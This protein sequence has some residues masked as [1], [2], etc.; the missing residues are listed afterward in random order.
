MLN[1]KIV[2]ILVLQEFEKD[3]EREMTFSM[4]GKNRVF[5]IKV[6]CAMGK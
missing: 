6:P 4:K 3:Q 2:A 1:V 5:W